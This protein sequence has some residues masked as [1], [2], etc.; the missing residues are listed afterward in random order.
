[1]MHT[2][3]PPIL[4][5]GV[6]GSGKTTIGTMLAA[7]LGVPFVDGDRLHPEANVA[8][9]AAGIPLDDSDRMPWLAEVARVLAEAGE[10]GIVVACS[11]LKRSYRDLIRQRV[12]ELFVVDP[13]G[14]IEVV[15][16]RIGIRKHEYMPPELLSSQYATLEPLAADERGVMVDLR[17]TPAEM[18]DAVL[19][20]LGHSSWSR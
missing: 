13:E 19:A 6:Q 1:M 10:T 9:M 2:T 16:K 3:L 17:L 7:R 14:P 18:L 11:A 12:R 5:M 4:V 20:G 15:A 8:K